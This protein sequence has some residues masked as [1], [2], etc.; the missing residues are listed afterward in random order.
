MSESLIIRHF[1]P[2]NDVEIPEIRPMTVLIGESGSGKSTIMKVLAMFQWLYKM[3][4][5]RS[6]M[7]YAGVKKSAFRLRFDRLLQENGLASFLQQETELEYRNGS[8][9]IT[10]ANKKLGGTN[11]NVPRDEIS[12]EKVVFISAKR[13]LIP[14]LY[15]GNA[16]IQK[17]MF[18]LDDTLKNYILA[19]SSIKQMK[20][21]PL[22]VRFEVKRTS[23][24]YK[25]FISS[26]QAENNYSIRLRDASSGTQNLTPLALIVEYFSKNYDLV[27]SMNQSVLSYVSRG[28]RLMDFKPHSNLGDFPIKRVSLFVEEPELSLFPDAQLELMD[29]LV[30]RCFVSHSKEYSMSLMIAT[31]S[32]YIVNYLNV[33]LARGSRINSV[34]ESD[35]TPNQSHTPSLS[36]N[37][38]A[39]YSVYDGKLQSLILHNDLNTETWVNPSDLSEAMESMRDE[40]ND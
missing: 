22:G 38:L 33:F 39:V 27:S 21:N 18:Y 15:E 7:K 24:G 4:C 31:H 6:Y 35:A 8:V 1:G 36:G 34:S 10:Y 3:I 37:D 14:D 13:S 40:L 23:Q 2:I 11:V 25:H 29:Y 28:D 16:K 30:D 20:L 5:L 26:L 12:L 9:T 32:P 17:E 19:T